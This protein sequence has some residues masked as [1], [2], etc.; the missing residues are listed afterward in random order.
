[1]AERASKGSPGPLVTAYVRWTLRYGR[2]LWAVAL[3]LFVPALYRT[4]SLYIHLKSDIEELLP[5][6]AESVAAIDELRARMPGLRYLGVI[7]DTGTAENVPA[8]EHFLDDLATRIATYPPTL[9][10]RTKTSVAEE[11]RFFERH[12]PLYADLEDLKLV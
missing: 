3:I 2:W 9:V 7:V 1:M 6:K 4:A 8:A 12:A 10:K 5:R 11:R